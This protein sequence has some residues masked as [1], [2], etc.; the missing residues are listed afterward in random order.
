MPSPA[1]LRRKLAKARRSESFQTGNGTSLTPG[2]ENP[3]SVT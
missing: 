2:M 3:G 1:Q